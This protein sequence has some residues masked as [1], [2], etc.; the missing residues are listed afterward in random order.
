MLDFVQLL[1]KTDPCQG[2]GPIVVVIKSVFRLIQFAI[3]IALI[4]FGTI[5]LG[6]AVI[7]SDEKEVKKA[8]STL[9][10][11]FI[12]AA[13]IFFVVTL[14]TL[15]TNLVADGVADDSNNGADTQSWS[16]CWQ[17]K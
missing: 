2:L 13:A 6:K 1:A 8:Q 7:S 4:L 9:I 15:L 14:V 5:D 17:N 16:R 10:K 11:R 12:Y 3:P